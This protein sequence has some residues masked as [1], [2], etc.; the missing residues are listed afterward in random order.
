MTPQRP[1]AGVS[2]TRNIP[3]DY[4]EFTT[5]EALETCQHLWEHA[6]FGTQ[7]YCLMIPA[8]E[9]RMDTAVG[10]RSGAKESKVE[11][12]GSDGA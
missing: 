9:A 3:D 11:E 1:T 10:R 7:S 2:L 12:V 5:L 4:N 8:A 6:R